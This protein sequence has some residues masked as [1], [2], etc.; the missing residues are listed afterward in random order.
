MKKPE[1]LEKINALGDDAELI[2]RTPDE[3]KA[4]LEN[5]KKLVS[6]QQFDEWKNDEV[7]KW[8]EN[9]E[10]DVEEVTLQRKEP[11][12]KSYDF[13]KRVMKESKERADK[14][15]EIEKKLRENAG[16]ETL[17]SELASVQRKY[18]ELKD[19]Y[20]GKLTQK[21]QTIHAVRIE[22]AIE[23][24]MFGMN[25]SSSIPDE[26]RT[27][28]IDKVKSELLKSAKFDTDGTLVFTDERGEII[29]DKGTL[30]PRDA[31][32]LIEERL[33]PIIADGRKLTGTGTEIKDEVK[34]GDYKPVSSVVTKAQLAEDM[35]K[36]GIKRGTKEWMDTY[37][38]YAV[39]LK[40]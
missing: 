29:R 34:P 19:E 33:K 21:D 8:H 30:K 24:A 13:N 11:R 17:K 31:K 37:N 25:F 38:K 26:L 6:S 18:K 10:K 40:A 35:L 5:H 20:E 39:N 36:N 7:K 28:Y 15:T 14:V 16:D 3:E 22:S 32:D 23:R 9:L 27:V 2:V 4:F 12:E 1:V